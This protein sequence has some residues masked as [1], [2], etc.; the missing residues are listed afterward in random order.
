MTKE[1]NTR[2]LVVPGE[3]IVSGEDYLPGDFT[4]KEG[5]E[6]IAG[7][8]GLADINGRV[9]KIIS[10]S[11]I[12]EPRRGNNILGRVT[13]LAFS[14]WMIDIDGPYSAFLPIMESPRFV[15]KNNLHEF[16]NIGDVINAK[17]LSVRRGSV[18][19]TLKGRG[20]GK[21][22][23]G[24]IIKI[25]PNKV[26]RVI[27]KEGSM[28]NLIKDK[29]QTEITI[30]Q[31][32]YIWINGDIEGMKKAEDAINLVAKESTSSGLTEIIEKFLE[33]KK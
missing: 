20:L 10:V 4:R 17:I 32:G 21:L 6:I 12:F 5:G 13:D 28:V 18:D 7:K 31:N 30:G 15:N 19:L 25:N 14:G 26:P 29:T 3:V 33:G 2:K 22:E 11:G 8:Y 27:G 1:N 16:A 24:R 9:V 23:G